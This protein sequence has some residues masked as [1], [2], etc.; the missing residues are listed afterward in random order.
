MYIYIIYRIHNDSTTVSFSGAYEQQ[1]P[2][3]ILLK[4]GHNKE[5]RP[6]YKQIVFGLN[7]TEDGHVPISYQAFNGNQADVTTHMPNWD[8]LRE[9]LGL[10]EKELTLPRGQN[11]CFIP[12][13][14]QRVTYLVCFFMPLQ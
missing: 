10:S 12:T 8:H 5:N 1:S 2:D 9:F 4:F 7:I 11:N 6:D 14:L 3:A 13:R